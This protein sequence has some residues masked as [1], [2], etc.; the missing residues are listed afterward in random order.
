MR[1]TIRSAV[2]GALLAG[3]GSLLSGC[4]SVTDP[5]YSHD[6][7]AGNYPP[8]YPAPG[9]R[10]AYPGGPNLYWDSG[11]G[12]YTVVGYPDYY[13]NDGYFYRWNGGYWARSH[14]WGRDW[15]RCQPRYLP[16]RVYHVQ[17]NYYG[18]NRRPPYGWY[19]DDYR[20]RHGSLGNRVGDAVRDQTWNGRD[21]H[22]GDSWNDRDNHQGQWNDR[23][24][25]QRGND[26][27]LSD[28]LEHAAQPSP[29]RPPDRNGPPPG[30]VWNGADTHREAP[31][32]PRPQPQRDRSWSA[33]SAAAVQAQREQELRAQR[34]A[35]EQARHQERRERPEPA[36][37]EPPQKSQPQKSD[38]SD[39]SLKERL[40]RASGG[41]DQEQ[42]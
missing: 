14:Y 27:D 13:W 40:E 36:R 8:A 26:R 23:D 41:S 19:D 28:R 33:A 12:L 39:R 2:L 42:Q 22:R 25:D 1:Q 31:T 30:H 15:A 10:Y 11:L 37:P 6:P 35:A 7:Y 21:D 9:Y 3:S 34:E 38:H 4:I 18:H 17:N 20:R 29:Q 32:P 5:G 24:G 16:R